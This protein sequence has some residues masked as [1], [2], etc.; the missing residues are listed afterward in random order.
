MV[1][2][3]IMSKY[4]DGIRYITCISI[5][6]F[7]RSSNHQASCGFFGQTFA[8]FRIQSLF[9]S[10]MRTV[11]QRHTF[12]IKLCLSVLQSIGYSLLMVNTDDYHCAIVVVLLKVADNTFLLFRLFSF[13]ACSCKQEHVTNN[14]PRGSTVSTMFRDKMSDYRDDIDE[15]LYLE[16][17]LETHDNRMKRIYDK[18]LG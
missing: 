8:G 10:V 9:F 13:F 7:L 15:E 14:Y 3:T 17:R 4:H 5:F 11:L 18:E 1:N 16:K 2:F 6:Q 12:N